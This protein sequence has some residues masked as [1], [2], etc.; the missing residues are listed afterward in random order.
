MGSFPPLQEGE[1][2]LVAGR[3]QH[4]QRYG[5]QVAVEHW[6]RILPA[7]EEGLKRYLSSGL[8]R[9][10][11]PVTAEAI[12]KAFGMKAL[13]IMEREPERLQEIPG[14]GPKKAAAILESFGEYDMQDVLVFSRVTAS[15][16]GRRCASSATT[17]ARRWTGSRKIPTSW[18]KR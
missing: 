11:G 8:I 16:W 4:H 1:S 9:G 10:I 18:P 12:V 5:R 3:W 13:E 2:L 15:G 7:T 17:A 14:I 6:E